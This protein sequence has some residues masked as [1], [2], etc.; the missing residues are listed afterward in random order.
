MSKRKGRPKPPETQQAIDAA[1]G[2]LALAELLQVSPRQVAR[3]QTIPSEYAVVIE[4]K[5]GLARERIWPDRT[6]VRRG[7]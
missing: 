6:M 1:G 7:G 5:L 2:V 3:W 4:A